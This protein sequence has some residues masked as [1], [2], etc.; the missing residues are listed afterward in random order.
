MLRASEVAIAVSSG[1]A[2]T[3]YSGILTGRILA[4]KY[5]P[6][7]LDTG[8]DLTITGETSGIAIL[9]KADAG[10]S[11]VW[12]FPR[13]LPNKIADGSAFTDAAAEP[14]FVFGERIKTVVAQGGTSL[15]GAITFYVQ[16]DV[17]ISS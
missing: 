5:A 12:F 13:I 4:I 10:T 9:T 8:A 16:D 6:G 15:A 14:P 3:V 1:G 17:Y 7:T 11:T 2:A